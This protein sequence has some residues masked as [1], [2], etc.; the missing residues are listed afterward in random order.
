M[1]QV[2]KFTLSIPYKNASARSRAKK[3]GAKWNSEHKVWEI[4]TTM[5][6]LDNV[7]N[8]AQF[9]VKEHG[10]SDIYD[11]GLGFYAHESERARVNRLGY[12]AIEP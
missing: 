1:D 6:K 10:K 12:D 5:Y 8:L 4:E 3:A 2:Q 9:I 7:R 11:T